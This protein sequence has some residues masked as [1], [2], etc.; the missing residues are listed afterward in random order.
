MRVMCLL[1]RLAQPRAPHSPWTAWR[2]AKSPL[3]PRLSSAS[4][5]RTGEPGWAER[6]YKLLQAPKRPQAEDVSRWCSFHAAQL[7]TCQSL[8]GHFDIY[9]APAAHFMWY[10]LQCIRRMEHFRASQG[11]SLHVMKEIFWGG[12][13]STAAVSVPCR[14]LI[15]HPMVCCSAMQ[16]SLYTA[17]RCAIFPMG[18]PSDSAVFR[19]DKRQQT[20]AGGTQGSSCSA[21]LTHHMFWNLLER[22]GSTSHEHSSKSLSATFGVASEN[23]SISQS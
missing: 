14:N 21:K 9:T 3:C 11:S 6:V 12:A 15:F 23:A 22:K 5:Q 4:T 18:Q 17:D 13:Y 19:L 7:R 16:L 2:G 10:S 20:T 8:A 1:Q